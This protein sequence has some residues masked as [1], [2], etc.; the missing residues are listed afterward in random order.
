MNSP[1]H[2]MVP[3]PVPTTAIPEQACACCGYKIDHATGASIPNSG[4]FSVCYNCGHQGK[5]DAQLMVQS[6]TVEDL[7]KINSEYPESF[8]EL[9]AASRLIRQRGMFYPPQKK[10]IPSSPDSHQPQAN[11]E[12]QTAHR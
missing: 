2:R 1:E 6:L 9:M 11:E 12:R 10:S 4:D 3:V 7:D 5:Y 8:D